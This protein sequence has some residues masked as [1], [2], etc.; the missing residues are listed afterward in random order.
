MCEQAAQ[1]LERAKTD[2]QQIASDAAK[3]AWTE[4]REQMDVATER[5][6]V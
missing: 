1:E 2:G 5:A 6:K 3:N 4:A